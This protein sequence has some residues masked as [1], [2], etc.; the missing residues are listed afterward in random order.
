MFLINAQYIDWRS[1][2]SF[3]LNKSVAGHRSLLTN[4]IFVKT[5]PQRLGEFIGVN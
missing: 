4:V 1:I 3:D 5:M 2:W